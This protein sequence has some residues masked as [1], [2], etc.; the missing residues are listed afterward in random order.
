MALF[1]RHLNSELLA[2]PMPRS[3]NHHSFITTAGLLLVVSLSLSCQSRLESP[4]TNAPPSRESSDRQTA[5]L[6][7]SVKDLSVSKIEKGL[8]TARFEDWVR[9]NAG[10]DWTITWAFREGPKGTQIPDSVDV[11]GDTKDGRYFRLSIGTTTNANRVFLFWLDGA[12]NVQHKWVFLEHLSQLPRMLHHGG[13][14]SHTS[15]G[16]K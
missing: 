7:A 14:R 6:I 1:L 4:G 5:D 13:Q 16:Q 9:E 10:P 2:Y 8:P 3:H 11:R 15:D 12:V